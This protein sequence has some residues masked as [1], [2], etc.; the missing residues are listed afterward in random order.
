MELE[1]ERKASPSPL[2]YQTFKKG[3]LTEKGA[4]LFGTGQR[5][6]DFAKCKLIDDSQ[7]TQQSFNIK[8]A[9]MTKLITFSFSAFC[10][11]VLNDTRRVS[12]FW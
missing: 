8:R 12:P 9:F 7:C 1:K 2:S 6:I 11:L 4:T 3:S 5:T 10:V